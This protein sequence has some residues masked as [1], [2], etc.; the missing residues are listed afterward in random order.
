MMVTNVWCSSRGTPVLAQVPSLGDLLEPA[1][2]VVL[3]E[4]QQVRNRGVA[5]GRFARTE[6]SAS[7][8]KMY[9]LGD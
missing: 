1:P 4:Q 8:H 3:V 9:P 6:V 5:F 2:D 7:R